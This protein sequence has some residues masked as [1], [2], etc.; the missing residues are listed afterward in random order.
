MA[1]LSPFLIGFPSLPLIPFIPLTS[2]EQAEGGEGL[3]KH[4]ILVLRVR[5]RKTCIR[6]VYEEVR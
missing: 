3:Q 5:V 2:K 1:L 4:P 6:V